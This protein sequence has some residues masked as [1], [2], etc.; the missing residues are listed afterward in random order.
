MAN[1]YTAATVRP[2]CKRECNMSARTFL[3]ALAYVQVLLPYWIQTVVYNI[4]IYLYTTRFIV[5]IVK[6]CMQNLILTCQ[7]TSMA[8]PAVVAAATA[9][10]ITVRNCHEWQ[11]NSHINVLSVCWANKYGIYTNT[12][13]TRLVTQFHSVPH[14][15]I[16]SV[17]DPVIFVCKLWLISGH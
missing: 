17:S 3:Q 10:I 8:A 13:V 14:S 1:T 2:S 5:K 9:T 6:V 15:V 7:P 12:A 16:H 11:I 4:Y